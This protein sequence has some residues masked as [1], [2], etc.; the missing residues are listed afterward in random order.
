[1]KLC[2]DDPSSNALGDSSVGGLRDWF[3][4]RAIAH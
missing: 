3:E 4:K 1:M 2:R